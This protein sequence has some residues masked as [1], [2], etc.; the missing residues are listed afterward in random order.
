M[1]HAK[2][3]AKLNLFLHVLNKR[4]SGYHELESGI[5]FTDIV[6]NLTFSPSQQITLSVQGRYR[7]GLENDNNIVL[8]AAYALRQYVPH[9]TQGVSIAL[10][11]NIPVDAGLGGGSADAAATLKALNQFWGLGL[12]DRVLQTIGLS[13]GADVPVCLYGKPA[14]V[15][16]IGEVINPLDVPSSF[17]VVLINPG[18]T[19]ATPKVFQTLLS[20]Q[21][22]G[23]VSETVKKDIIS[24][25]SN[26]NNDL[27]SV[28]KVIVPEIST[29]MKVLKNQMGCKL[30]RMSGSG[31]TCFGWFE[32]EALAQS[33]VQAISKQ[34]PHWWVQTTRINKS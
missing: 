29:V 31:A 10:E 7:M 3:Y 2:A 12:S 8:R 11:K 28:S 6:D 33:A 16:G 23:A 13:L 9:I 34:S 1:L 32:T 5:V 4:A 30:A 20:S 25:I 19:L 22:S 15:S 14:M 26:L 18:V 17:S 21:W 27:E 24:N